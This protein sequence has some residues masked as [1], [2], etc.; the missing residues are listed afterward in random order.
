[1]TRALWAVAVLLVLGSGCGTSGNSVRQLQAELGTLRAELATLRQAHEHSTR[2]AAAL[3]TSVHALE[4]EV[5]SL[6][7]VLAETADAVRQLTGRLATIEDGVKSTRADSAA[8]PASVAVAAP[9]P[10][11]TPAAERPARDGAA[12]DNATRTA[13]AE[14]AYQTALAAFR[15][16]E[17]GQA[18]LDFLDFLVKHPKHSLAANAQYWIGEA[19]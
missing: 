18:V 15:A 14:T 19:Y 2:D 5:G 17:H 7:G 4:G 8:R 10:S 16:R 9:P 12:R 11:S 3:R 6:R 13:A 1:M